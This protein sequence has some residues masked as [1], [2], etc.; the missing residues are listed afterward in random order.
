MTDSLVSSLRS[1]PARGTLV[2]LYTEA[3]RERFKFLTL[4]PRFIAGKLR[5]KSFSQIIT[6][7]AMKDFFIPIS[8]GQGRFVYLWHAA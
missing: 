3:R 7:A 5:G 1:D 6:P 2:R 8:P 4:A